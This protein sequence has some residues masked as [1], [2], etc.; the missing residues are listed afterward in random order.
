MVVA[1]ANQ[2]SE[3]LG[4][5]I[6]ELD[7][8]DSQFE[9]AVSRYKALGRFLERYWEA[10]AADGLIYPQGSMLLGTITRLYH[11]NDEY[12]IDLVC[13][14]DLDKASTTQ[15]GLKTE[16]GKGLELFVEGRPEGT[17]SLEPGKRCWTLQYLLDHFHMD[18]L[19]AIPNLQRRPDGI[20][21]TDRDVRT[22]QRSNPLGFARWFR[23][24]M[25]KEWTARRAAL[26]R[27]GMELEDVPEWTVKT[28]LQ[29]S[30]QALKRH[31]DIYFSNDF[32]NRTASV[33]ITTLAGTAYEGEADLYEV[34]LDIITK[35]PRLVRVE[36][37]VY[38][39][40][41][42]VEPHE[43]FADRWQTHPVRASRFFEWMEQAR[44]DVE[45]LGERHGLDE[46]AARASKAFGEGPVNQMVKKSA[47]GVV[48]AR[49]EGNLAM[50]LGGL[51][52]VGAGTR[53]RPHNFHGGSS[54]S[55]RP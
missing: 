52:S 49:R 44:A 1:I 21:I 24:V 34:L 4:S 19:P 15:T 12:D 45:S 14:R 16:V 13:R 30:V 51:L 35:M 26:V 40:K 23:G 22:W 31:R 38:V 55:S 39:I 5:T 7:I 47:S 37:G 11:R 50:G 28:T 27:A 46:F 42:P 10:D 29:R 18:V 3:F 2:L 25:A 54:R 53:S 48:D 6:E 43:N 17:P 8:P 32:Q 33:I 41:N 9:L 36:S 20:L